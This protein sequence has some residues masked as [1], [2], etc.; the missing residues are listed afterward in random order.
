[1]VNIFPFSVLTD[2][3]PLYIAQDFLTHAV[4]SVLMLLLLITSRTSFR[5]L[6]F[7]LPVGIGLLYLI[8]SAIYYAAGGINGY[9][10]TISNRTSN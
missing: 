2:G 9:V 4:N 7:Y 1:M 8:F 5:I 6:H 3:S 10:L